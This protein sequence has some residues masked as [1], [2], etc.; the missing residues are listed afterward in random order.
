M[1]DQP[2]RFSALREICACGMPPGSGTPFELNFLAWSFCHFHLGLSY[3][4]NEIIQG[5]KYFA[6]R[7][8]RKGDYAER[9]ELGNNF[10]VKALRSYN[11][12][13][14]CNSTGAYS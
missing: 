10:G 7:K 8:T 6:Y 3:G 4:K 2:F 5:T 1:C 13:D 11:R 12:Q 9:G 14:P